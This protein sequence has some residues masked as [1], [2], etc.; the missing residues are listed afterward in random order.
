MCGGGP[1]I[2]HGAAAALLIAGLLARAGGRVLWVVERHDLFAP[3]LQGVGLPPARLLFVE[4][5]RPAA[6][7]AVM[8][9]ALRLPR[10]AAGSAGGGG[11]AAV[12]GELSGRLTL[13]ASRR[14]QL[15]AEASGITGFVLRR[16][17]RHGDPLLAAP[18]AA[19]TRWQV[20]ALP[21]AP[22]L[23][24][25]P[26]VPG[27]GRARWRLDLTRC[28]G[29]EPCSWIVEAADAQGRLALVTD[30]ADRSAKTYPPPPACPR[31]GGVRGGG[32]RH[33]GQR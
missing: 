31:A 1:D 18:T 16:S 25:A 23:P 21:S 2:E 28:R 14:L 29:G 26:D 24:E 20:S 6:V 19:L 5:G 9:E 13:T 3:A 7:L 15:A 30:L 8:E 32:R 11:L 22:P 17:R 27:L 33:A 10:A 12:V 4:A